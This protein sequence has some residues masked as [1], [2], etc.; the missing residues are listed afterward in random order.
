MFYFK[1]VKLMLYHKQLVTLALKK[2]AG[3]PVL[4]FRDRGGLER[5]DDPF[6]GW[7]PQG[8]GLSITP[9]PCGRLGDG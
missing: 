6:C 7:I 4:V 2:E 5:R 1:V 3:R 9:D 8:S